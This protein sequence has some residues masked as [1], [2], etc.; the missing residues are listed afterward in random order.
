MAAMVLKICLIFYVGHNLQLI[1]FEK[2]KLSQRWKK[3]V[4]VFYLAQDIVSIYISMVLKP[5]SGQI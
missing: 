2:G 3:K 4:D 1:T 5:P